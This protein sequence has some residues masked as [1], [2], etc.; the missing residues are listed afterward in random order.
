MKKTKESFYRIVGI[1]R[2]YKIPF[3]IS[4]W[5]AAKIYGSPR[6]LND[7]DIDIPDKYML[8]MLP[9]VRKYIIYGPSRYHDGAFD[10]LLTTL[11]YKWQE[12]DIWWCSDEQIYSKHHKH[13]ENLQHH[14]KISTR[15]KVYGLM[16]PIMPKQE[17]IAYKKKLIVWWPYDH[18]H[19]EDIA[20]IS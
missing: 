1:L 17:L 15:K 7:I 9:D 2:K 19:K 5:F 12:I 10:L 14:I 18:E 16:V 20:A 11:R 6:S 13:R 4:G 8:D 3:Q